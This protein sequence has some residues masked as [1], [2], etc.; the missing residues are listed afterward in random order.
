M[1]GFT[2]IPAMLAGQLD[3]NLRVCDQVAC[4]LTVCLVGDERQE[5]I[6]PGQGVADLSQ[7]AC[8]KRRRER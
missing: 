5:T 7:A 2:T 1:E 8:R 3:Y 6:D 4:G